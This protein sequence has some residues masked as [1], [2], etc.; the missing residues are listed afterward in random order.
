VENRGA[1]NGIVWTVETGRAWSLLEERKSSAY[2]NST[3]DLDLLLTARSSEF[4][5]KVV[6]IAT[7]HPD[8]DI[9]RVLA[10]VSRGGPYGAS[11][12]HSCRV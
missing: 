10:R 7:E 2:V 8:L 3:M 9:A 12:D 4:D 1:L 6:F 11:S 5:H